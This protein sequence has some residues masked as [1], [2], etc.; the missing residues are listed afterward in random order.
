MEL[1]ASAPPPQRDP[2]FESPVA[3]GARPLDFEPEAYLRLVANPFLALF[4]FLVWLRVLLGIVTMFAGRRELMGPLAPII[5]VVMLAFL[6]LL[7]GLFQFH[8]LDCGK[9]GRL[10]RWREHACP[11]SVERR[12]SGRRRRLRGPTPPVQILLWLWGLLMLG[13]FLVPLGRRLL[14]R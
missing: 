12:L 14:D 10:S 11:P 9:T 1:S 2:E 4:G 7:L 3:P 5:G 8:C 6:W 13:W